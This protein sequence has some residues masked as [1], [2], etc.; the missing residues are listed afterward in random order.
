MKSLTCEIIAGEHF[1]TKTATALGNKF[2][3][4]GWGWSLRLDSLYPCSVARAVAE[5]RIAICEV[6]QAK[7]SSQNLKIFSLFQMEKPRN[8]MDLGA[9]RRSSLSRISFSWQLVPAACSTT[10]QSFQGWTGWTIQAHSLLAESRRNAARKALR[11]QLQPRSAEA[12][13]EKL[14]EAPRASTGRQRHQA[15]TAS[16][17]R[18]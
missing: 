17:L 5:R 13:R 6:L 15:S 4:S 2:G 1:S 10:L 8:E 7:H 16:M 9:Q 18:G 14:T 11:R 3:A 12:S